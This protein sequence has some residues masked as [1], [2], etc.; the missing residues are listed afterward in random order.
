MQSFFNPTYI[1]LNLDN[2]IAYVISPFWIFILTNFKKIIYVFCLNGHIYA[3]FGY[4]STNI[5]IKNTTRIVT[6]VVFLLFFS[7]SS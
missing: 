3:T 6:L 2:S 7:K 4:K 5:D 1:F